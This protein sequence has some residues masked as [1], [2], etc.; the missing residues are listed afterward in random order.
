MFAD[1]INMLTLEIVT[2]KR[3]NIY[4]YIYLFWYLTPDR[5]DVNR[6]CFIRREQVAII[7]KIQNA[8]VVRILPKR[9]LALR[10]KS[11]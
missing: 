5:I 11:N 6:L 7:I 1:R 9:P 4:I 2:S 8:L 3:D 10:P